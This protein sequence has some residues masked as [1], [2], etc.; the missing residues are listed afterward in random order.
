MS[1]TVVSVKGI[2]K[3]FGATRALES[4]SFDFHKGE[5]LAL[6]GANGAGKSTLI[7]I[8]C[9]YYQDYEG[10]LWVGGKQVRFQSPRDAYQQGI[11]TVHQVINQGVVQNMSVAENLALEYLLSDACD[12]FIKKEA[13]RA[14]AAEIA[15][16][17]DL[18]LDLD[19]KV[20]DLGQ[21]DRQLLVIA[22]NLA[23]NPKL[24]ILDEPTSSISERETAVLFEKL[25]KLRSEGVAILYVSH[26]LHEIRRIAGRVGVIRDG[27][28]S[29]MLE[30]P[31]DVKQIVTAMVG[32]VREHEARPP[33]ASRARGARLELKGLV[34]RPGMPPLDLAAYGGEVLGITGL[35]G[36]GKS[37]L[38]EALFGIREPLAGERFLDGQVY[39]GRSIREAIDAGIHLVPEDRANNAVIRDF[40]IRQNMTFP[41]LR[42]FSRRGGIMRRGVEKAR[43]TAMVQDM[44]I[45]CAGE[46]APIDSLSGGNQQK[47]IV[48]R[49]LLERCRVLIL[50]EPFQGVDIKSRRDIGEFIRASV[51]DC[52]VIVLATDL[53][54]ILEVADRVVVLNDGR[55]AGEQESR[56]FDREKL[57]HWTTQSPDELGA[58]AP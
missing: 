55:V 27:K 40:T 3:S 20:A 50:D 34:A 57:L 5:I 36:A 26:R 4:V 21:S 8:I 19:R 47:V 9:G 32:Q 22:R 51:G 46:S 15:S 17:M 29:A 16:R 18:K 11:Q 37:E 6:V 43:A 23:S 33:S 44:G 58:G 10:E 35:I 12:L 31:F 48:A 49:W 2:G 41:F 30:K 14:R 1:E 53:D 24:L 25:E 7:K 56:H 28:L 38:A 39:R 45:K 52:A 42:R 13:V 54:E